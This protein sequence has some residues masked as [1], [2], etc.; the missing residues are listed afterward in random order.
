LN[1]LSTE[2]FLALRDYF[3][4]QQGRPIPFGLRPKRNTQDDPFDELLAVEILSRIP[5]IKCV[6]APGPL[7]TP[8]LV[9]FRHENCLNV[10]KEKLRGDFNKIIAIEVKKL[11]RTSQGGVARSSGLDYNTTPP[12]GIVRVY[13]SIGNTLDIRGFYLFVCLEADKADPLKVILSALALVDGNLLNT[14]FKLYLDVVGERKKRIN[15]GSYANGA[16]RARPML[17]FANPLGAEA[18]DHK[19]NLV[20]PSPKLEDS[21]IRL[22]YEIERTL[23]DARFKNKFYCYRLSSDV[24][25][26]WQ[27]SSLKDPFPTPTRDSRTRPRGRFKLPFKVQD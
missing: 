15:L 8:D 27:V 10:T 12:C 2:A 23:P 3:F 24:P 16:D 6:K 19:I 18:L 22:V 1:D 5:N 21:R 20:H 17:I 9:L 13:D 4:N 11:E 7:I 25:K 14:D 26:D